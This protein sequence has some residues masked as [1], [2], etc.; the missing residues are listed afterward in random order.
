[1]TAALL[2]IVT[3]GVVL[4]CCLV[5]RLL[6][7]NGRLLVR[8]DELDPRAVEPPPRPFGNLEWRNRFEFDNIIAPIMALDEYGLGAGRFLASDVIV[9]VG[10]HIGAFARLCHD[11]GSRAIYCYEPDDSNFR[12]LTRNVGS[13]P[14]VHLLQAAVWRSDMS[15]GD[16]EPVLSLS[17]PA[18][19]NTGAPSVV[20]EGRMV[21]YATQRVGE[22]SPAARRVTAVGLDELLL[23]HEQVRLLKLDCEGSEFPIVLTS[24]HLHKARRIV[25]EVHELTELMMASLS[26]NSRIVGWPEYRA[27]TLVSKL[28][29]EGFRVRLRS[30][31]SHLFLFSADREILHQDAAAVVA[32]GTESA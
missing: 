24:R 29:S 10:A 15:E 18:D 9:D 8:I 1:M 22:L 23:K 27:D 3:A 17:G 4:T 28:E 32:S 2:F 26:P 6:I 19:D 31:S 30:T 7:L 11:R 12:L 16:E 14:G 5:Y 13:L 20:A 25:G 21:D